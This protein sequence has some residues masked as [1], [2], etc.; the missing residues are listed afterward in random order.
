MAEEDR[1]IDAFGELIYAVAIADGIVQEEE[2]TAL[3][4][5]LMG[6]PWAREIQWSFD[7]ERSK[8]HSLQESYAKALETFK[9]HGPAPEYQYL[10]EILERV[11][12]ASHG[13]HPN[14]AGVIRNFQR[15]LREKFL[16]DLEDH[17]LYSNDS[18]FGNS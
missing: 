6:H 8:G 2:V 14:E 3:K 15:E 11:S 10:L 18:G 1:L 5:I 9:E 7:Y 17:E 13:L 16:R 12:K 4:T